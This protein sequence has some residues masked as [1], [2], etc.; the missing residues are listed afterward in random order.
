[1]RGLKSATLIY[2]I[3]TLSKL[4]ESGEIAW[5]SPGARDEPLPIFS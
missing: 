2:Q 3:D 4:A 5:R 1:V